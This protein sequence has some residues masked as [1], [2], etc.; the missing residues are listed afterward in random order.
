MTEATC[1]DCAGI[2]IEGACTCEEDALNLQI[3]DLDKD[4]ESL[5]GERSSLQ[6]QLDDTVD[7]LRGIIKTCPQCQGR[8]HPWCPRCSPLRLWIEAR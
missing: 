5:A 3:E 7:L 1:Q 4:I 8:E 2:V 6:G